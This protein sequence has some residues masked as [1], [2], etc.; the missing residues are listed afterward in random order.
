MINNTNF[1]FGLFAEII[2]KALC[3]DVTQGRMNGAPNDTRTHSCRLLTVTPP[4]V[5]TF[6]FTTRGAL[7]L[8]VERIV[9]VQRNARI[10]SFKAGCAFYSEANLPITIFGVAQ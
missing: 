1:K 6:F 9:N 5:P 8:F 4:E 2:Y 10:S 7:G 3:F